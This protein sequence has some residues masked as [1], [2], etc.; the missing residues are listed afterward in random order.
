MEERGGVGGRA[1]VIPIRAGW[2]W[3][4]QGEVNGYL[5]VLRRILFS[6]MFGEI[7]SI[8]LVLVNI[9]PTPRTLLALIQLDSAVDGAFG[10]A[11]TVKSPAIKLFAP[12][13]GSKRPTC[14]TR[15]AAVLEA[16]A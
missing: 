12:A 13:L 16:L 2:L 15:L 1:P 11:D 14:L 3:R 7:F 8:G 10:D 4:K 5:T 6:F 9:S